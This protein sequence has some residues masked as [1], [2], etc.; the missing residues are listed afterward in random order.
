MNEQGAQETKQRVWFR[1]EHGHAFW[2]ATPFEGTD[3]WPCPS[4]VEPLEVSATLDSSLNDLQ[5]RLTEAE[6]ERDEYKQSADELD[7][8]FDMQWKRDIEAVHRWREEDVNERKLWS[9][10]RGTLLDYIWEHMLVA[11]ARVQG[12]EALL[13]T[14]TLSAPDPRFRRGVMHRFGEMSRF[15]LEG[16]ECL[17]CVVAPPAALTPQATETQAGEES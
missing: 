6:R 13:S 12:L 11:E 5:R 9:P 16:E 17:I 15:H 2:V 4:C 10:D 14:E 3:T 7:A 8:L 1:C